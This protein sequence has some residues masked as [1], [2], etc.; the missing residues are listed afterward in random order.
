M[1]HFFEG[2]VIDSAKA[3]GLGLFNDC[4]VW[5]LFEDKI[6]PTGSCPLACVLT[7]PAAG[8]EMSNSSVISKEEGGLKRYTRHKDCLCKFALMNPKLT[9]TLP[10][11]QTVNGCVDVLMHTMERYFN[12]GEN[13]C[14]TDKIAEGIMIATIHDAKTLMKNPND[15]AARQSIMW[16]SSLSHNSLTGCGTNGGDWATHD[17]EHELSGM[18]DVPHG[19]GLSAIW[20]SWARYVIDVIPH[21]LSQFAINVMGI[22]PSEDV[23]SVALK[24]IE[25]TEEFFTSL[26]S[27]TSL[28]ELVGF[29]VSDEQIQ[30]MAE[31]ATHFGVKSVGSVIPLQKDDIVK[32]FEMARNG[33]K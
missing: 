2:S 19:A 25:A 18:F 13:L 10:K 4:D 6:T 29:D 5:D 9:L 28:K 12:A 20:G 1:F 31:K 26:G 32:I 3:I 15:L 27:S 17:I 8:S 23:K 11:E 24:G 30:E 14:I 21:R 22:A 33:A 16:A 7:L